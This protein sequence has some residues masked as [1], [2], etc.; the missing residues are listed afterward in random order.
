MKK[1]FVILVCA[2]MLSGC[3]VQDTFETLADDDAVSAMATAAKVELR[4]PEEAA[5]PSMENEDGS[6]LYL[7]DGYTV[8]VQTLDGGDLGRTVQQVSGFSKEELTVMQTKKNGLDSYEMA[9]CA[10]GEGED[11]ICRGV[12]LDDGKYHYAVTV[13]ANYSQAGALRQT[14]QSILDSVTLSTD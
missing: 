14:W 13:M 10:A 7:C 1:G 2:L 11:Q 12:I 9:W 5:A 3:G 8:T 4:L 6:K